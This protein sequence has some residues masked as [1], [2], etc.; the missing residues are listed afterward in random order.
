MSA[1]ADHERPF[2]QVPSG[3]WYAAATQPR[4]EIHAEVH[5]KRQGFTTFL[6]KR[7]VMIRHARRTREQTVS[8][9]PGYL[10]IRL[11]LGR[12]RWRAVN[13]TRGVRS[14]VM[15]GERPL[16]VPAGV[17]ESLLRCTDKE[18][19]FEPKMTFARGDRV[20]LTEGSLTN[21]V[22]L[23]DADSPSGRVAVL[24]SIMHGE[25]PASIDRRELVHAL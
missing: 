18:G 8:F 20:R 1:Q 14:L 7:R 10:F 13:G 25:V 24:L 5:L 15:Q 21:M 12:D 9:F 2:E 11:D 19:Q 17:I 4:R 16:P 22:G 6:P 23:V 3:R